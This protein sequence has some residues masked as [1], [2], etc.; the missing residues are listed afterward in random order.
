MLELRSLSK[1]FGGLLATADVS[2]AVPEGRIVSLIGPNGAG[3][4]T[5]FAIASGFL[6]P[7]SGSIHFLGQ[8]VT[9]L[10]PHEICRLG[11]VR[12]FQV[13]KP[14]AEQS[15]RENILVGAHLRRAGHR[16]A[17]E[18]ADEVAELVGM[19][20]RMDDLAGSLTIAG[21]KR[22]ELA[23]A[24][25]TE[26]KLLLLDEVM[27]GL[28]PTEIEEIIPV[29]HRLRDS[30][31]TIMLIEHVM[32]AVMKLSEYTWVLNQ[33]RLIAEGSPQQIARDPA[34]IEAYLGHGLAARIEAE[35]RANA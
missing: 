22:L 11:L 3:K 27:A 17:A 25:A 9:G 21:R 1:S 7:D 8:D 29:I 23:K 12:T 14:F 6:T 13:V 34:V 10:P 28:N 4:T 35:N 20:G 2:L 16:D 5:L 33:G 24:L 19:T 32:Q 15:V 31:L 18:K 26:P 30:G